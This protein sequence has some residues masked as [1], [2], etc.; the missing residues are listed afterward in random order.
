MNLILTGPGAEGFESYLRANGQSVHATNYETLVPTLSSGILAPFPADAIVFVEDEATTIE[1]DWRIQA[2]AAQLRDDIE[3]L[4]ES[5]TTADGRKYNRIPFVFIEAF[6]VGIPP[7]ADSLVYAVVDRSALFAQAEERIRREVHTYRQ[8]LLHEFS[9][10]GFLVVDDHG[11]FRVRPA[12][13]P[14]ADIE[15]DLFYATAD[16]LRNMAPNHYWTIDRDVFGIQYE[17]DQ[18]EAHIND[19][20]I[21]EPALQA[22]FEA[23]P[24][25]L[26]GDAFSIP[27]PRLIDT[28]GRLQIP[29]FI[30]RPIV[31]VQRDSNWEVR[32][33][34][35]PQAPILVRESGRPRFSA[36]IMD[37]IAQL[38]DYHDY[39]SSGRNT[40]NVEAL[41]GHR[42]RFPRLAVLVGR[43]PRNVAA[44]ELNQSKEDVRIITYDEILED[45][46]RR[47]P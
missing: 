42:L 30:L 1:P 11:R 41:L 9:N 7:G 15:G 38:R 32:D 45:A 47:A 43:M 2:I 37:A 19:P 21:T 27:H 14:V 10:H 18:L 22:F 24:S 34:K 6:R 28:D 29:D 16:A 17:V 23:N 4:P 26:S 40:E 44:L 36:A 12:L 39:F 31:S 20:E 25:L 8:R 33:L 13:Q 46:R 3:A 35:L 5:A